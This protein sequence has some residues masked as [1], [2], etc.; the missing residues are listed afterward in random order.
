MPV[1]AVFSTHFLE[2]SQTFV[3][4][5]LRL[6]ER[7]EAEVFCKKRMNAGRFPYD[8]V[9]VGWP[10]YDPTRWDP[11]FD[12]LF[13]TG[14]YAL[15]HAHF[16]PG[17]VYA[18]RYAAKFDL[19]FVVTFHGYDVPL[20]SS[21]E[22]FSP[23]YLRY[24]ILGPKVLERMTLGLC[25]S[26]ELLLMLRELGVPQERLRLHHI[27][28]DTARFEFRERE[29]RETAEVVMVG[30]FV[31]KKGFEYGLRAFAS[32]TRNRAAR[33]TLVGGGE[34]EGRLR[35]LAR[36]LG[37]E[38]RVEFAGM[39]DSQGV[40]ARLARA[41]V[42]LAPSVVG[43]AGNRESGLLSVKEASASGAVPIGTRHG[44]IPEIIDDGVTGFLVPERDVD[45]LADRLGRL[46]DDPALRARMARA[47]REKMVREY[48]NR[49][50]VRALE[51]R[52]DEAIETH[53]RAKRTS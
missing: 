43:R 15:V 21:R 35:R 37:I 49:V 47:A 16:G 2:Y 32:A 31:E 9:H 5:E 38:P 45:A 28:V 22:R 53:A 4:D 46:L 13:R 18:L 14:R 1:V 44:G 50:R 51:A 7:Y 41:D 34:L 3:F 33:L 8:R 39:L 42:L 24:A 11:R 36:E 48:D 26:E 27:G 19:P 29:P 23:L 20:L 17:G 12:A 40:A 10:L 30:R 25:A 6:H 52:Y